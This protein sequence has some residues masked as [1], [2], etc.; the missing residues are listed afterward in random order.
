MSKTKDK[1][2]EALDTTCVDSNV[3]IKIRDAKMVELEIKF[4]VHASM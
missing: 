2:I 4:K 1:K 3:Q